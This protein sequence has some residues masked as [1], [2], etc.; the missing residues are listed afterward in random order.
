MSQDNNRRFHKPAKLSSEAFDSF[1]Q[2]ELDPAIVSAIAHD[3]AAALVRAGREATDPATTTRLVGLI[4]EIGIE[5]VAELWAGQAARSLPG[6][7]WRLYALKEWIRRDPI[8]AS[9]EYREGL[10]FAD[11]AAVV[12]GVACPPGP[13]ELRTMID[14]I[15]RGV[16]DGDLAMAL[17]RA[18]AFCRVI[19]AGRAAHLTHED[20]NDSRKHAD[21]AAAMLNT[22]EDLDTCAGMWRRGDLV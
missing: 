21:Q 9:T 22:G 13:E 12:A 1:A 18:G 2:D 20:P 11:V 4:D 14:S 17:H 7:L 10:R 19:A 15:L 6:A 5:I 3:T 16:F 8:G